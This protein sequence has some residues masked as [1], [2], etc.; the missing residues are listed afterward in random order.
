MR[1]QIKSVYQSY[2]L[3][4]HDLANELKLLFYLTGN[5]YKPERRAISI[6]E[7]KELTMK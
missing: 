1:L 5:L 4:N 6:Q 3:T 2:K 7:A